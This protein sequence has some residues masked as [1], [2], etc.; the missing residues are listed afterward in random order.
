MGHKTKAGK[1]RRPS[2]VVPAWF[3]LYR[4]SGRVKSGSRGSDGDTKNRETLEEK[5]RTRAGSLMV[6][7]SSPGAGIEDGIDTFAN[8]HRGSSRFNPARRAFT[9]LEL[10]SRHEGAL[11]HT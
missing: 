1:S 11:W 2:T 4:E 3:L 5:M 7:L 6:T 10:I 9:I 8:R